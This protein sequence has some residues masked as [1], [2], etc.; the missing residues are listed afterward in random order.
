MSEQSVPFV[1][2]DQHAVLKGT[3]FYN[4]IEDLKFVDW[5]LLQSRNFRA[6][7]TDAGRL[8]RYMA[9]ALVHKHVPTAHLL[10][11]A[12]CDE[13]TTMSIQSHILQRQLTLPVKSLPDW[14]SP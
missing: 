8:H 11:V 6:D 1:F 4:R 14:F 7:D 10:G 5:P 3:T 2:T 13:T 9:E 12:C